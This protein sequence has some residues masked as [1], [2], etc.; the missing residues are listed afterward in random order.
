MYIKSIEVKNP[1]CADVCLQK[2]SNRDFY[3]FSYFLS[4]KRGKHL[5]IFECHLPPSNQ[6]YFFSKDNFSFHVLFC[7]VQIWILKQIGLAQGYCRISQENSLSL[8]FTLDALFS[9]PTHH[10]LRPI[11]SKTKPYIGFFKKFMENLIIK[12][13]AM[14]GFQKIA[15]K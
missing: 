2:S 5:L 3:H 1:P 8:H 15:P 10:R 14:H 13:N 4:A 12:Q 7:F 11:F 6:Q 9:V